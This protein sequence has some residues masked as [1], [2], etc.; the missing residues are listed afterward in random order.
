M[1]WLSIYNIPRTAWSY[2]S[3]NF[4]CFRLSVAVCT[5]TMCKGILDNTR[6]GWRG[7]VGTV[8]DSWP[9]G[10]KFKHELYGSIR[11]TGY[12]F[13]LLTPFFYE[14][15]KKYRRVFVPN[16]CPQILL[17]ATSSFSSTNTFWRGKK[18][19]KKKLKWHYSIVNNSAGSLRHANNLPNLYEYHH[20]WRPHWT[21][22][23]HCGMMMFSCSR[24][25]NSLQEASLSTQ[26]RS[27]V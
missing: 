15:Y 10:H 3:P 9:K 24:M 4:E 20:P 2:L 13:G 17:T 12:A 5:S 16:N 14:R 26:S 6:R 25:R 1:R 7:S 21:G 22:D 18:V 23:M 27:L 8:H 19:K 11:A